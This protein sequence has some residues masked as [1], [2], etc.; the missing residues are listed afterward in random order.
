MGFVYLLT[1]DYAHYKIGITT[2]TIE[3]RLR[4]LQTGNSEKIEVVKFYKTEHYF[5]LES[6]LH[7]KFGVKRLEGEWFELTSEDI[8][9]FSSNC[10]RGHDI[11]EML[12][13]SG[14]PFI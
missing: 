6:W 3:K 12:I 8:K 4:E 9:N 11:F 7:R 1:N 2:R 14:N 5:A 10:Q 13:N